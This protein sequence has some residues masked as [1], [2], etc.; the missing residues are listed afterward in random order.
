M[1]LDDLSRN[2]VQLDRDMRSPQ[3][4]SAPRIPSF[5]ITEPLTDQADVDFED[6][7]VLEFAELI[8]KEYGAISDL[9]FRL[10]PR[11]ITETVFWHRFYGLLQVR[12]LQFS[13]NT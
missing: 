11:V 7:V 2:D 10:V 8:L 4:V 9:R 1:A 5:S 13:I 6:P 3:C 12:I